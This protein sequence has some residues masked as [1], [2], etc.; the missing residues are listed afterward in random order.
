[1]RPDRPQHPDEPQAA[2]NRAATR[3]TDELHVC[4][5][6]SGRFVYPLDWSEEGPWHWRVVLRCPDCERVGTG[7]F[8]QAVVER[9]DQELDRASG[10]LLGDLQRLTHANMAKELEFFVRALDADVIVPSDF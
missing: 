2:A 10:E 3:T 6:C 4:P 8:P 1:M 7:V 5:Y 9:F